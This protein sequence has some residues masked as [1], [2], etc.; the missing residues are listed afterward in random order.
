MMRQL[1]E[2]YGNLLPEHLLYP[3]V[4]KEME[5]QGMTPQMAQGGSKDMKQKPKKLAG[6]DASLGGM[7]N[8]DF[9]HPFAGKMHPDLPAGGGGNGPTP[10]DRNFPHPNA[11]L[12]HPGGPYGEPPGVYGAKPFPMPQVAQPNVPQGNWGG[13]GFYPPGQGLGKAYGMA[14]GSSEVPGGIGA[15]N[16]QAA[17]AKDQVDFKAPDLSGFIRALHEEGKKQGLSE[18][19]MAGIAKQFSGIGGGGSPTGGDMPY[20]QLGGQ[21]ASFTGG[22][23]GYQGGIS[24][25]GYAPFVA[26]GAQYHADKGGWLGPYDP[27][28]M[29]QSYQGGGSD[30]EPPMLRGNMN[31]D[32]WV[33]N[34][35]PGVTMFGGRHPGSGF[36]NRSSFNPG[37]GWG[38]GQPGMP[39]SPTKIPTS[40]DPQGYPYGVPVQG[41]DQNVQGVGRTHNLRKNQ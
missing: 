33:A 31:P 36:I 41:P 28:Y 10:P 27:A 16:P 14:E 11:G 35:P 5:N 22:T 34:L 23:P 8:R 18:S 4:F 6:G 38:G 29:F 9:A 17:Y 1:Y 15:P 32:S 24:E 37:G 25:I 3:D 12:M 20:D 40:Y 13:G 2:K 21:Y 19:Q 39:W 30:V 7:T 26:P